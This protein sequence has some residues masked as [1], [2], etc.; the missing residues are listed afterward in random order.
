MRRQRWWVAAML[1]VLAWTM[2]PAASAFDAVLPV[3]GS[4]ARGFD[5]PAERWLAGHRGV[6]LRAA[7][8]ARVRAAMAG[9]VGFVGLVAG[10]P[11]VTVLHGRLR[12]T[13][14]PVVAS[15]AEGQSVSVGEAI[16]R[17]AEGHAC[18]GGWC[19]HWGL[20]QGD[21][22]LDPMLLI[23]RPEVQLLPEAAVGLARAS[24]AE[25]G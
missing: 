14:E 11:V 12:T 16:G 1:G 10:K 20:K 22:Y 17:L 7:P 15:V 19:L 24:A 4:L 23:R 13:Y 2:A 8:G 3:S 18:P 21:T 25:R 5:P 6:D 9:R